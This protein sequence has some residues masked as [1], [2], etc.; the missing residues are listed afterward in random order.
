MR[1]H[2]RI[3]SWLHVATFVAILIEHTSTSLR[4]SFGATK[5]FTSELNAKKQEILQGG[6]DKGRGYT[7]EKT[8]VTGETIESLLI[9]EER[10]LRENDDNGENSKG[11]TYASLLGIPD[12]YSTADLT[13]SVDE[14]ASD[15]TGESPT[16][17]EKVNKNQKLKSRDVSKQ[18]QIGEQG[19]DL[20]SFR[21]EEFGM[22]E[23]AAIEL[24][25]AVTFFSTKRSAT[26]GIETLPPSSTSV[27]VPSK[28]ESS[29]ISSADGYI[30]DF[31]P[32]SKDSDESSM[33]II[34][35]MF[36]LEK[37]ASK[38]KMLRKW[39]DKVLSTSKTLQNDSDRT[40]NR[41]SRDIRQVA[42][43]VAS[44]IDEVWQWRLFCEEGGGLAP[45]FSSIKEAARLVSLSEDS[46][47]VK[48]SE[49]KEVFHVAC[50]ACRSLRDLCALSP[51]LSAVIT[52]GILDADE[53]TAQSI[54]QQD[55][56][57][58][59]KG[60]VPRGVVASLISLLI[61]AT[62]EEENKT[63][64]ENASYTCRLYII[65]FLLAMAVAS[66]AAVYTLRSTPHFINAV[67]SCSSFEN[68]KQQRRHFL[69]RTKKPRTAKLR[70]P[71][72]N[73]L[74]A[75]TRGAANQLLAAV[76][77]NVWLPKS[78][79]Q[80]GLRILCL[81]GGGTRGISAIT[82]LRHIVSAMD[83]VEVCDAFD[84][85]VGTSTG[86][87]IGFLVGLRRES[88][89]LARKRYDN[90][91]KRIFV[92]SALATPM[93]VFTTATYDEGP[94]MKVMNEILADDSMLNSRADPNVPIVFAV[95]SKMSSSPTQLCLFRNYNYEGGGLPD[96]F[97]IDPSKA[98][99]DLQLVEEGGVQTLSTSSTL[100][101]KNI[102]GNRSKKGTKYR[103][104]SRHPGSFRVP[105][106]VGMRAT[107][108]APTVFKPVLMG[109]EIY[110][111]GGI[112]AS[113]PTAVAIHEARILYPDVPIELVVSCGTGR[114][115]EQKSSPR[116]GWD[117]IISQIVNS[118]TD[119]EATHHTLEDI[120]GQDTST[121]HG[122]S[123][124][125]QT[126][127]FRFNPIVG[128]PEDFPIDG[129]DPAILEDLCKIT[130]DYLKEE[131]QA[132]KLKEIGNIVHNRN[133]WWRRFLRPR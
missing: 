84:M 48:E 115:V 65:Q 27:N 117:G 89:H 94:F 90:L 82:T 104:A 123:K 33:E 69:S 125:S 47:V 25:E 130:A 114:F 21:E 8:S 30:S 118:A 110:C 97:V 76:G 22:D 45:I 58:G 70:P 126:R 68:Q 86:A 50:V 7:K 93:L 116:V 16:T 23:E 77:H 6:M 29:P 121:K 98:R 14:P 120:L 2:Q 75:N 36:Q 4:I 105:Q 11:G 80:K 131:E 40:G 55:S 99:A 119:A 19:E 59:S 91:I 87:I 60:N 74:E 5:V 49:L 39:S 83:G 67:L 63:I 107:T 108:A 53:S 72:K 133:G 12:N 46:N 42:V 26:A 127:Y 109:G 81:D 79:N 128:T 66:D 103:E 122:S 96:S 129:T 51:E 38:R 37:G 64:T 100:G 34:K 78:P 112:V 62:K 95:A 18:D 56:Q 54:T 92:K 101:N 61:Y 20:V 10:R 17:D 15:E 3:Q 57:K 43:S 13:G 1:S 9:G 28:A 124:V 32:S 71:P 52:E 44:N 132:K 102:M 88:A 111:D 35:A 24:D 73:A 113:N 106:K 85:I 31:T 41:I